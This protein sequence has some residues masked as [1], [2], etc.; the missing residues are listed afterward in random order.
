MTRYSGG[1][2]L[3]L[4]IAR[5]EA[6]LGRAREV[7]PGHLLAGLSALCRADLGATRDSGLDP[8]RREAAEADAERLRA[9]FAAA[10]IDPVTLRRR[11]R[12]AL[13]VIDP[14]ARRDMV[15][16]R[17]PAA[18]RAFARAAELAGE[19]APAGGV[20]LLRAVLESGTPAGRRVL[21]RLGLSDPLAAFFPEARAKPAGGGQPGERGTPRLDA[22][23]RDLTRLAREGAAAADRAAPGG[24]N[25]RGMLSRRCNGA[26]RW[27]APVGRQARLRRP[28]RA[29]VRQAQHHRKLA[30]WC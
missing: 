16:H 12:F 18:R 1:V 23:G 24:C 28:K 6:W 15:P 19:N 2:A 7:E 11:L 8:R 10:G 4:R 13:S 20:E 21:E 14:G 29:V 5:Y 17:S 27:P 9:C 22:C 30:G 26:P 25:L 3:A